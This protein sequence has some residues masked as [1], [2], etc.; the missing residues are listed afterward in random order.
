MLVHVLVVI[1]ICA[2]VMQGGAGEEAGGAT[3]QGPHHGLHRPAA[4]SE[5]GGCH[6]GAGRGGD[7]I[8]DG[9]GGERHGR[10]G[11][12]THHRAHSLVVTGKGNTLLN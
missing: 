5:R 4:D 7:Y 8:R 9:R 12:G 11:S 6:S 3:A 10:A 1:G 2:A